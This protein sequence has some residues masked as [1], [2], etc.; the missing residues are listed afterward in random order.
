MLSFPRARPLGSRGSCSFLADPR[1]RA[2]SPRGVGSPLYPLLTLLR[3]KA[4]RGRA[5]LWGRQVSPVPPAGEG[6]PRSGFPGTTAL[7][8]DEEDDAQR[9]GSDGED[10]EGE[11]RPEGNEGAAEEHGRRHG[12]RRSRHGGVAWTQRGRGGV[13]WT[14][15]RRSTTEKSARRGRGRPR[16]WRRGAAEEAGRGGGGGGRAR[17]GAGEEAGAGGGGGGAYL[18]AFSPG[19]LAAS[20]AEEAVAE[21]FRVGALAPPPRHHHW[22]ASIRPRHRPRGG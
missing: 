14:R 16:G 2:K 12:D 8:D 6:S 22:Y 9:L 7:P 19:D 3:S 20:D 1:S 18:R 21:D 13:A 5:V 15:G 4:Q 17:R 10:V 11:R